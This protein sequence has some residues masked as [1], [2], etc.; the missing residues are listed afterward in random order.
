M[1]VP[2]S[3]FGGMQTRSLDRATGVR[4][5]KRLGKDSARGCWV[6]GPEPERTLQ[7]LSAR[8]IREDRNMVTQLQPSRRE[9]DTQGQEPVFA[10]QTLLE[11]FVRQINLGQLASQ[12]TAARSGLE[13]I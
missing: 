7:C 9:E 10:A 11:Q 2:A 1:H 13:E 3:A 4:L 8:D 6:R 5:E 12:G